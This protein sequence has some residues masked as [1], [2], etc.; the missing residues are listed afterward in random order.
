M[1]IF[2]INFN[3]VH[4]EIPRSPQKYQLTMTKFIGNNTIYCPW[5]ILQRFTVL[6]KENLGCNLMEKKNKGIILWKVNFAFW[7]ISSH[8]CSS[9]LDTNGYLA[10]KLHLKL[11]Y[12]TNT[13][14]ELPNIERA[15]VHNRLEP[16][17]MQHHHS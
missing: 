11:N 10:F 13:F 5:N 15:S 12:N 14:Q 6:A 17:K 4:Y 9:H 7:T 3:K 2:S 1:K 16:Q 8:Q